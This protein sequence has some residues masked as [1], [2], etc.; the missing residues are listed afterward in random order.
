MQT[1]VSD[2]FGGENEMVRHTKRFK[3]SNYQTPNELVSLP[4]RT[5]V[6]RLKLQFP[7]LDEEVSIYWSL[8]VSDYLCFKC[9]SAYSMH[10]YQYIG[11]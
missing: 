5:P 8:P 1:L 4:K 9:T 2:T 3:P 6:S 11:D 10:S 7:N